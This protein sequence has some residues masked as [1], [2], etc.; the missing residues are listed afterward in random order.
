[1]LFDASIAIT[2]ASST[3]S[4]SPE[5]TLPKRTGYFWGRNSSALADPSL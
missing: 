3:V 1:M 5:R 2:D 4:T